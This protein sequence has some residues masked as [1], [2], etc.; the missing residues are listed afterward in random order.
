[1]TVVVIIVSAAG[2]ACNLCR[3]LMI[4]KSCSCDYSPYAASPLHMGEVLCRYTASP[5]KFPAWETDGGD[6]WNVDNG[7]VRTSLI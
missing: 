5:F 1:M 4:H 3:L 6:A 7:V 2:Y